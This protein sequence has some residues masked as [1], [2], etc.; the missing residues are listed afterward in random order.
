MPLLSTFSWRFSR[1]VSGVA[2]AQASL[3]LRE[4]P[5]P[6]PYAVCLVQPLLGCVFRFVCADVLDGYLDGLEDRLVSEYTTHEHDGLIIGAG[7]AGLRAAIAV[8]A[9]G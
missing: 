8:Y 2:G 9:A 7:G 5:E 6:A 3:R 1:S 4:L